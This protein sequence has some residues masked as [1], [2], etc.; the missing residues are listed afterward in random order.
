MAAGGDLRI[1]R[2]MF[3][4]KPS[5]NYHEVWHSACACSPKL[6]FCGGFVPDA[7]TGGMGLGEV[8]DP[9]LCPACSAAWVAY[10]CPRCPCN[11]EQLCA[12]CQKLRR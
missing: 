1:F 10:G 6:N 11:E 7:T 8:D 3:M 2:E 9:D 5:D 4:V 12:G